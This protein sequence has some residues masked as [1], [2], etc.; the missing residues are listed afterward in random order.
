M[1][2]NRKPDATWS[3][4]EFWFVPEMVTWNFQANKMEDL[5]EKEGKLHYVYDKNRYSTDMLR[6]ELQVIYSNYLYSYVD[7]ILLDTETESK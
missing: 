6:E 7:K 4:H 2:P 3:Q 1:K 5:V